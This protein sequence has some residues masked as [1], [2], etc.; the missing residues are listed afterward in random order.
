MCRSGNI[1]P[2]D[3]VA[4]TMGAKDRVGRVGQVGLRLVGGLLNHTLGVMAWRVA[5]KLQ[6][7]A[8]EAACRQWA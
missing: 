4:G 2:F 8:A 6:I 7:K 3:G 5:G 1:V